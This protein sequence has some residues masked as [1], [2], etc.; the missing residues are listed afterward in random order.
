[1]HAIGKKG[2]STVRHTNDD[3]Q[4]G[5]KLYGELK[6]RKITVTN[7]RIRNYI[8]AQCFVIASFFHTQ[9]KKIVRPVEII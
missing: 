1:M 6:F 5:P 8:L 9:S 7:K 2:G 3:D 4:N